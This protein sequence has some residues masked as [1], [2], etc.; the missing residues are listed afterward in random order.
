VL[1]NWAMWGLHTPYY[2]ENV[3]GENHLETHVHIDV[4]IILK[5]I[6]HIYIC[7]CVCMYCKCVDNCDASSSILV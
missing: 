7:V 3:D 6:F 5:L 2:L 4:G 1:Y